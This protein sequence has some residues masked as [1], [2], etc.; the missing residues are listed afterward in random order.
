MFQSM[1]IWTC[2]KAEQNYTLY[3]GQEA[4]SQLERG[5]G[6]DLPFKDMVQ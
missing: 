2:G 6:Q 4:Q 1:V 5:Q 3:G